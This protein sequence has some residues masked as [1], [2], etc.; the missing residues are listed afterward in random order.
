MCSYEFCL[1]TTSSAS[2]FKFNS[3]EDGI[4]DFKVNAVKSFPRLHY[5][6][7]RCFW[8]KRILIMESMCMPLQALKT[9]GVLLFIFVFVLSARGRVSEQHYRL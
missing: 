4:T 5:V 7:S 2:V 1:S 6:L 9:L 8:Q 3:H